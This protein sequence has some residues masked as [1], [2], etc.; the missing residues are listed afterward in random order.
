MIKLLII[1][2]QPELLETL[3][4]ALA[5]EYA[6]TGALTAEAGLTCALEI[7]PQ[8]VLVDYALPAMNGL[9]LAANLRR[10]DQSA[11]GGKGRVRPRI[12]MFSAQMDEQLAAIALQAGVDQC[13]AKP[14]DLN[15]LKAA[16]G[17]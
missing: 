16:I 9:E 17:G 12:I 2:D 4:I 5:G 3:E 7:Q 6:V 14:F 13:L 15:A 10:L 8:V 11:N 1:E